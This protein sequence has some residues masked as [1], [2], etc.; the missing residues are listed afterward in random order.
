[1]WVHRLSNIN[2]KTLTADC[3]ECGKTRLKKRRMSKTG[4]RGYT[5]KTSYLRWRRKYIRF[6]KNFCELCQFEAI[7]AGQ[8]D[9][10]H[11][12]NNHENNE[13]SNLKTLCANCHRLIHL[14]EK[15]K[16]LITNDNKKKGK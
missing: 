3:T 12:D 11:K 9:V 2:E 10:H 15:S 6:K 5:C 16:H 14:L 4:K 8:L 13:E 7:V 1:M